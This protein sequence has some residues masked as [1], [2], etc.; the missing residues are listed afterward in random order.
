VIVV[1]ASVLLEVLLRSPAG[2]L[3][4]GRLFTEPQQTLHAPH[5]VDAEVAQALR[6]YAALGNIDAERGRA[7]IAD[8]VDFP[9]RRYPHEFLLTRVWEMRSNITV[10]DGLYVVLAEALDATLLTRDRRLAAAATHH[11]HVELV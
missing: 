6:R 8:L 11:A 10:Y 1:D 5:L 2:R 7:A 4:E 3:M 9:V